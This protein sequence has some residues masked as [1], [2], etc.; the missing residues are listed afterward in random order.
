M[1]INFCKGCLGA[2]VIAGLM[3]TAGAR[4]EDPFPT[5]VYVSLR[6]A[7]AVVAFPGGTV[8]EGGPA[9]LYAALTPDGKTL[10][11]TSPKSG[12]VFAFD[13]ATGDQLAAVATG[14]APKGVKI[15]PD[16][17]EAWVSNEAGNTLSVVD[18]STFEVVATIPTEDMPHNVRFSA[19]GK[20]GY[21]TLQGGAG[22]GVIDTAKREIV[23]VIPVPGIT[24]PH[25][26]DLSADGKTAWVRDVV[27]SVA[28][29]DLTTRE[30]K[31]VIRAATGHAGI[32]VLP[33]GRYVVTGAIG[34]T[35]VTV[36]DPATLEVV[37]RIPVGLGPHGVRASADSRWIYATITSE[38][39]VVV[40]DVE[41][42]EVAAEYPVGEFPFWAAV[43]GNF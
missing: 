36:I 28:V 32:D 15:T 4:A 25:N 11:V 19:D 39:K 23:E 41:T 34:D 2:A 6:D 17:S 29:L 40:I 42:L 12:S 20:T 30:V 1:K 27:D 38:N 10:M 7:N 33:N 5:P 21:V 35:V 14:E 13:A 22:I 18:L 3:G 43:P 24:G 9:M 16:G 26:L 31:K 8:W 37:K